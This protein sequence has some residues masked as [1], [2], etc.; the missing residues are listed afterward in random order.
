[1]TTSPGWLIR[2]CKIDIESGCSGVLCRSLDMELL[3]GSTIQSPTLVFSMSKR[4]AIQ[5][6]LRY[7]NHESNQKTLKVVLEKRV[8]K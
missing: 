4:G 5:L 1:V 8:S 6:G 7:G 2:Y 3:D